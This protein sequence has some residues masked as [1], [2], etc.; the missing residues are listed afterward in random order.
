MLDS[1]GNG[2]VFSFDVAAFS[3]ALT[4]SVATAAV[5]STIHL[6]WAASQAGSCTASGSWSGAQQTSGSKVPV[7]LA[8]A[9]EN[10][11]TLTCSSAND[12]Q[13]VTSSVSVQGT[14]VTQPGTGGG[15]TDSGGGGGP[16]SAWLLAPLAALVWTR[17]R[18]TH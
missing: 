15:A 7:V 16:L 13:P 14:T 5:G 18:R 3:E 12:G 8:N 10:T 6:S 9:G 4:S 11:Y 2:T 1:A 17:R